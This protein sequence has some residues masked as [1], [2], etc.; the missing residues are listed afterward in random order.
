MSKEGFLAT[1]KEILKNNLDWTGNGLII[2]STGL[3]LNTASNFTGKVTLLVANKNSL[4]VSA[5]GYL[6]GVVCK[7]IATLL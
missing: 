6:T 2:G 1:S 3:V 5:V 4:I 7:G